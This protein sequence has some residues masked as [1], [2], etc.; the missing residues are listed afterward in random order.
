MIVILKPETINE[1][2]N[3]FSVNIITLY[4]DKP[5]FLV[6]YNNNNKDDNEEQPLRRRCLFRKMINVE[7]INT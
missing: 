7:E 5:H 1:C 3:C 6:D 4:L 2:P